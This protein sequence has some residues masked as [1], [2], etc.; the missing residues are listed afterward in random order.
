M[1]SAVTVCLVIFIFYVCTVVVI[2]FDGILVTFHQCSLS[3]DLQLFVQSGMLTLYSSVGSCNDI[4][5]WSNGPNQELLKLEIR[6]DS[7]ICDKVIQN[8]C[9]RVVLRHVIVI[10]R[11]DLLDK[12][13]TTSRYRRKVVMLVMI[14]DIECDEV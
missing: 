10:F 6:T 7:W 13:Q 14:S 2:R 5:N 11:G 8:P 9:P 12:G 1:Y 4:Q 3:V